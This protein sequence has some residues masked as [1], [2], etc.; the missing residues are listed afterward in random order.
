[1]T[2]KSGTPQDSIFSLLLLEDENNYGST[3]IQFLDNIQKEAAKL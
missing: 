2:I 1:M 3:F